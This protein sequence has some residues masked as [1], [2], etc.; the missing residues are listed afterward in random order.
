MTG[1]DK[2][3]ASSFRD[4]SGH[5][6]HRDG[7]LYRQ[8]NTVYRADYELLMGSGLYE[9]LTDQGLMVPHEEVKLPG[10]KAYKVLKPDVIP[11]ISYPYEWSF[12]QL[13]D[14]A[15]ATLAVQKE[16]LQ[17][18]MWLKDA[19]AYNIQFANGRPVLIDTL[20][21]E[22]YPEDQPW[23]A[24][25]QF[26]QHFLAP[27]ALA[28]A[29]DIRLMQLLRVYIDGVPLDLAA[30]LLPRSS[31]LRPGM[32]MHV[33]LHARSQTRHSADNAKAVAA[34]KLPKQR[35]VALMDSLESAIRHLEW[36]PPHTTWGDYYETHS[37][38]S[39]S[40]DHK[41]QQVA[42]Y[43]KLAGPKLVWDLGGNAG[44]FSRLASEQGIETVCWDV[45]EA[46]VEANYRKIKAD[47]EQHLLPLVLDLTN[48]SPDAGWANAERDSVASRGPADVAL[49]LALVH[50]LAIANNVPL[51]EIA[52]YFARL[53]RQLIIEFVPKSDPM[54]KRLLTGR[55]DIFP[56]YTETGFEA[57]FADF[58]TITE[59]CQI[60]GSTRRLYLMRA[61]A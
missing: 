41:Q 54:V 33:H 44:L 27:L 34:P 22:A 31:R 49:A 10:V 19:S 43:L 23:P 51:R 3:L 55:P 28:A 21:L 39:S 58:F 61:K 60:E 57:A 12:S 50:H 46:A 15:L 52:S 47:Q 7:V 17:A 37:Y 48:P 14:A 8:V 13:K 45:D 38:Q 42:K 56:D 59:S 5:M 24:Y 26:C 25:R 18:G 32:A 30:K 53:G 20:S 9:R 29:V 1:S 35:L 16:A 2:P 4:P 6:F 36:R 11:F 40:F